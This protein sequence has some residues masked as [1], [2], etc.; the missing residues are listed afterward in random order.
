MSKS[1][2]LVKLIG[3]SLLKTGQTNKNRKSTKEQQT[4]AAMCGA[5]MFEKHDGNLIIS[6]IVNLIICQPIVNLIWQPYNLTYC[7]LDLKLS[8][9]AR[10]DKIPKSAIKSQKSQNEQPF[11]I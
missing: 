3:K 2:F 8:N 11:L 6:P 5:I 4:E 9:C 10:I 7:P 1:S